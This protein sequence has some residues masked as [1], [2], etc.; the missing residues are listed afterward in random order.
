M[1]DCLL[2]LVVRNRRAPART[3]KGDT[4]TERSGVFNEAKAT[5]RQLE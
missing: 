4:E 2:L 5:L 1:P 3:G